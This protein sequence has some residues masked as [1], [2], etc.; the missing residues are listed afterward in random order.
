[1]AEQRDREVSGM[2]HEWRK[3]DYLISTDAARLDLGVVHAFLRESYWASGI[4]L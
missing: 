2:A 1:M 3:G 4:P